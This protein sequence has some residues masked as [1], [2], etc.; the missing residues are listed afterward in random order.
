M[1]PATWTN[2]TNYRDEWG[3]HRIDYTIN[4]DVKYD[5]TYLI[6]YPNAV[7]RLNGEILALQEKILREFGIWVNCSTPSIFESIAD[8][9]CSNPDCTHNDIKIN[10]SVHGTVCHGN[11]HLIHDTML[12]SNNSNQKVSLGANSDIV[13]AFIGHDLCMKATTDDDDCGGVKFFSDDWCLIQKNDSVQY[14]LSTFV[15]ELGHV[16]GAND[17]YGSKELNEPGTDI[18][19]NN[20][21]NPG[22][23]AYIPNLPSGSRPYNE[24][25]IYGEDNT[26]DATLT[27][28][29]GCTYKIRNY[30][31]KLIAGTAQIG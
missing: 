8:T 18:M 10:D 15:H 1:V 28:C 21:D 27:I 22:H 30:I 19:N 29:E 3:L 17:H 6:K 25:C 9:V 16:L 23:E 2:D 26:A 11:V 12:N 14:E 20:V 5:N 31:N 7:S 4:V 13:A 24:Y